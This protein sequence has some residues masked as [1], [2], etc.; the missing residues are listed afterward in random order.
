MTKTI[1]KLI[2]QGHPNRPGGKR[3]GLRA[4]VFHYTANDAPGADAVAVANYFSRPWVR[5]NGVVYEAD[6]FGKPLVSRVNNALVPVK[7]RY[8]STQVC[9]DM[10]QV[11]LMIPADE[12][13]WGCGDRPLTWTEAWRGQQPA[14]KHWFK[15]RQNYRTLNIEVC[16]NDV[17]KNSS[18]D[19]DQA[20]TNAMDWAIQYLKQRGV[21]V[22]LEASLAPQI[23]GELKSNEVLILRHYD[24]T[25]KICPKPLIDRPLEWEKVVKTIAGCV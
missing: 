17:L 10:D 1:E 20:L 18:R 4:I 21:K 5:E 8:G 3:E 16:N 25:G 15:N 2:P 13:A 12:P 6:K 9:A 19:W 11:V 22:N 7:F 14:A 23:A 24:I